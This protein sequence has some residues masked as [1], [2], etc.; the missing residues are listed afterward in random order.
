[1]NEIRG[2]STKRVH[3]S[4]TTSMFIKNKALPTSSFVKRA[5][6]IR[7]SDSSSKYQTPQKYLNATSFSKALSPRT[8]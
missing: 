7:D 6:F 3:L 1:M 5:A 8:D 4:T 2:L